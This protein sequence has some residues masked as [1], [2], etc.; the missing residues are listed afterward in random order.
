MSANQPNNG[1]TSFHQGVAYEEQGNYVA[2][3][4]CYRVA[5]DLGLAEAQFALGHLYNEGAKGITQ[6]TLEALNWYKKAAAQKH[7]D[8][9][10]ALGTIYQFGEGVPK[11]E[12]QALA[13]YLEAAQ[14]GDVEAQFHL[15]RLYQLSRSALQNNAEAIRWYAMAAAQGHASAQSNLE[16]MAKTGYKGAVAA[17]D[18]LNKQELARLQPAKL[19]H[20]AQ[21]LHYLTDPEQ[22]DYRKAYEHLKIAVKEEGN[23]QACVYFGLLHEYKLGPPKPSSEVALFFYNKADIDCALTHIIEGVCYLRDMKKDKNILSRKMAAD[24]FDRA[25]GLKKK[26]GDESVGIITFLERIAEERPLESA[27]LI[28]MMV[29]QMGLLGKEKNPDKEAYFQQK[30]IQTERI[31]LFYNL[32]QLY[33]KSDW[34]HKDVQQAATWYLLAANKGHAKASYSLA[35]IYRDGLLNGEK[36]YEEALKWFL[37]AA[38]EGGYAAAHG[39]VAAMCAKGLGGLERNEAEADRRYALG[40]TSAGA[41]AV[42]IEQKISS[43]DP[44]RPTILTRI[45][46]FGF[47]SSSS[48]KVVLPTEGVP[49]VRVLYNWQAQ[50]DHQLSIAQGEV[51]YLLRELGDWLHCERRNHEDGMVPRDFVEILPMSELPMALAKDLPAMAVAISDKDIQYGRELGNGTFGEVHKGYWNGMEVAVKRLRPGLD[52]E[53]K[54]K[55]NPN[56]NISDFERELQVM[57]R[58]RHPNIVALC[59]YTTDTKAPHLVMEHMPEGTLFDNLGGRENK[60]VFLPWP[61]RYSLALNM[62]NGL[63]YLHKKGIIHRDLKSENVL[64]C[65]YA[66]NLFARLSDF[67]LSYVSVDEGTVKSLF[68]VDSLGT[69]PWMAPELFTP[70][71]VYSKA[72]DIYAYAMI[73]WELLTHKIPYAHLHR[74]E[75]PAFVLE[76]GRREDIPPD[77]HHED[78]RSL[79]KRGWVHE[80]KQRPELSESITLLTAGLRAGQINEKKGNEKDDM[81]AAMAASVE[82][83]KKEKKIG[84]RTIPEFELEDVKDDGNCFYRAVVAQLRRTG[85]QVLLSG[86]PKET[87][88]HDS[89]RLLVQG[90]DF[91]DKEWADSKEI[92]KIVQQTRSIVA[93]IDTRHPHLG[94]RCYFSNAQGNEDETYQPLDASIEWPII[95]LAFTGDH[96]LSVVAHP[97]LAGALPEAFRAGNLSSSDGTLSSSRSSASLRSSSSSSDFFRTAGSTPIFRNSGESS[98][99]TPTRQ[100]GM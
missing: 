2:A 23:K 7:A 45:L 24:L 95:R 54:S 21:G 81:Q 32:G 44:E 83:S 41:A 99:A 100:N 20:L 77:E 90:K 75:I 96:Y 53:S 89:L 76:Q 17:L 57:L 62:A 94:F 55:D 29:Y 61:V 14:L 36:N 31:P 87:A 69:P 16:T 80:A 65:Y 86:V 25:A 30:I 64:I 22:P 43:S 79:I 27:A 8:A 38:D 50:L 91:N 88:L 5:A 60:E 40:K 78:F 42:N 34:L 67:G 46:G 73:L 68:S 51:L 6:N 49:T 19:P 37:L 9:L 82:M 92:F 1:I 71:K 74:S 63:V 52:W 18:L 48:K 85:R 10:V 26:E 12:K 28:L 3:E 59:A 4:R 47:F 93:V 70:V 33:E 58:L 97:P 13:Y 11:N 56:T 84:P 39:E 72:T 35:V 98:K 15:G 66:G